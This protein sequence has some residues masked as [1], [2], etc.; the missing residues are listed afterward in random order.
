MDDQTILSMFFV[1]K[2]LLLLASL[3]VLYTTPQQMPWM[4]SANI[5]LTAPVSIVQHHYMDVA[6]DLLLSATIF[7]I[8][9][10]IHFALW[11]SLYAAWNI[12]FCSFILDDLSAVITSNLLPI[13][14]TLSA[15]HVE[16]TIQLSIWSFTRLVCLFFIYMHT[17]LETWWT[18]PP[19]SL[20][21]R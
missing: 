8:H 21:L 3:Y 7:H 1:N 16:Y 13:A 6:L 15:Y 5:L 4:I 17:Y 18:T 2:L 20:R 9:D 14:L 10:A 11:M 12:H 19:H